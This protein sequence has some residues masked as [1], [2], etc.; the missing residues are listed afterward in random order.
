MILALLVCQ[1]LGRTLEILIGLGSFALKIVLDQSNGLLDQ[2]KRIRAAELRRI[3]TKL[4]PTFVKIG[5]GL[6]TRPDLCPPEYLEELS[7][8]QVSFPALSFL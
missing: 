8:L 7:Q 1:V 2:N 5:Q 4:G 6:S 3:F